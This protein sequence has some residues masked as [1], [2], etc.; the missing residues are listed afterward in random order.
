V[1][2]YEHIMCLIVINN[3]FFKQDHIWLIHN[4]LIMYDAKN[5]L[6]DKSGS[7]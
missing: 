5:V 2:R 4:P 1:M 6:H 7:R 3:K